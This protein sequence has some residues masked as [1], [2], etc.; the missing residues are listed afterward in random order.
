MD[1]RETRRA[2]QIKHL[3]ALARDGIN[4]RGRHLVRIKT[5]VDAWRIRPQRKITIRRIHKLRVVLNASIRRREAWHSRIST[6]V[7]VEVVSSRPRTAFWLS[8]FSIECDDAVLQRSSPTMVDA[9]TI[10]AGVSAIVGN[11]RTVLHDKI[12]SHHKKDT[13]AIGI[14][15]CSGRFIKR[16]EAIANDGRVRI[17]HCLTDAQATTLKTA[18]VVRKNAIDHGPAE[19]CVPGATQSPSSSSR[20]ITPE[21][22]IGD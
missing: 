8:I 19:V 15:S 20:Y 1:A 22:A 17:G 14:A 7:E 2:G 9:A 16:K 5:L 6:A 10:V 4:R 13:A 3:D 11:D 18:Q 12:A 21:D